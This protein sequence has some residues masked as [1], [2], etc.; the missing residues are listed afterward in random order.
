MVRKWYTG[1]EWGEGGG[2]V[3]EWGGQQSGYHVDGSKWMMVMIDLIGT[4]SLE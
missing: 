4:N 2:D 3:T 1:A